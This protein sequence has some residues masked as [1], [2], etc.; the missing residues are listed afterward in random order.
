MSK[1]RR[2]SWPAGWALTCSATSARQITLL[3]RVSPTR[4]VFCADPLAVGPR[5]LRPRIRERGRW[6][7]QLIQAAYTLPVAPGLSAQFAAL[8]I[9]R[10]YPKTLT[11]TRALRRRPPDVILS[12]A[13]APYTVVGALNQITQMR[14]TICYNRY[15]LPITIQAAL[16]KQSV[17]FKSTFQLPP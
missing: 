16:G 3:R 1:L 15:Y 4:K 2:S 7:S 17:H 14:E 6:P 10:L 5:R 13:R 12:Y 9:C 8:W 11:Y